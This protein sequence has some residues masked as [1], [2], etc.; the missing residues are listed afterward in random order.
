M[1]KIQQKINKQQNWEL[2]YKTFW[3]VEI[4]IKWSLVIAYVK[5]PPMLVF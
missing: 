1:K 4:T 2:D 3:P 5:N